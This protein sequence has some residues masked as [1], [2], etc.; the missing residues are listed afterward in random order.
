MKQL[1]F[2]VGMGR[3]GSTYLYKLLNRHPRV[4]LTNESA[5]ID[6]VANCLELCMLPIG[7]KSDTLGATGI[8][9]GEY[10]QVLHR[11]FHRHLMT[12]FDEFYREC[13]PDKD[14]THWGDKLPSVT[15]VQRARHY[16]PDMKAL[17]L[18]RDPRDVVCSYRGFVKQL[19]PDDP[20]RSDEAL[21][22][23]H[24]YQARRWTEV[25]EG[26]VKELPNFHLVR[27]EELVDDPATVLRGSFE[28]LG[29]P[30]PE[31]ATTDINMD[32]FFAKQATSV[33]PKASLGRWKSGLSPAEVSH[34]ESVCGEWMRRFDYTLSTAQDVGIAAP[35]ASDAAA[36]A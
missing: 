13:F 29:L 35:P 9:N 30:E 27:Y 21:L 33:S 20:A 24:E 23:S 6:V 31:D 32:G 22:T 36:G 12:F 5:V 18:V 34:I 3:S 4:A 16:F 7:K 25:Y 14:Y 19:D 2:I 8:V 26:F 15:A 28:Y 11:I 10:H 17:L 1:F